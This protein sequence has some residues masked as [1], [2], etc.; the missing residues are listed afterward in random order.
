MKL[1]SWNLCGI[2]SKY[3]DGKLDEIFQLN[4]DIFCI[5][6]L[7]QKPRNL[8]KNILYKEG[9]N[10]FFYPTISYTDNWGVATYT[11]YEPITLKQG[12]NHYEFDREGRI[13]RLEFEDFNLFN[14]YFP[15]EGRKGMDFKC[16]FYDLFTKYVKQ[17]KKPQVICGDFNRI[18]NL[19]DTYQNKGNCP[20]FKNK[21][22]EKDWF[23]NFLNAGFIDTFRLFNKNTGNYTYWF[24]EDYKKDNKGYRFDYFLVNEELKDN[25][26]DAG[27][28][29]DMVTHD[30]APITL[31]L[32]F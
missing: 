17:S 5:Q 20:G 14:V 19:D 22:N 24:S 28:L 26:V 16:E 10:S 4:P 3:N 18:V 32:E 1:I 30:H 9:Y 27:I 21:N 6:E 2:E 13:Q 31:E 29:Q 23:T 8:D 25:V 7:H 15:S 12:F 11:Q